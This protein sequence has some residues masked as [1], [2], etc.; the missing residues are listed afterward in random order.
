VVEIYLKGLLAVEGKDTRSGGHDLGKI[1]GSLKE[2][3]QAKISD[4]YQARHGQKL[5]DDLPGYSRLFV[6]L[7]YPYELNGAR[8]TDMSGVAQLASSL[9]ETWAEV[10]PDLI[11]GG[12]LHNRIMAADQGIPIIESKGDLGAEEGKH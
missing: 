7:R 12:I 4:R 5:A 11:K 10:R 2:E 3:A 1:F 8:E 6:D 9:Y